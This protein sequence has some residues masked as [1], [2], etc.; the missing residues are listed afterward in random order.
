MRIA[1]GLMKHESNSFNPDLTLLKD[2]RYVTRE[3]I[4]D[5]NPAVKNSSLE[6]IIRVLRE[7]DVELIPLGFARASSEGGFV[8][9]DTYE[10]IKKDFIEGIKNAGRI[11]GICLDLHGSMTVEGYIDAEGDLLESIR[12]IIGF[13]IPI[14]CALDLHAMV[15]KQMITNLN[16]IVGYR[17]APHVDMVE[18]GEKA[19]K[20]L[21]EALSGGY[22]LHLAG[23][24]LPMLVS[25]EQ[26]ETQKEPMRTL[27]AELDK[28]DEI[29]GVLSTSYFLGF[30][31]ADVSYN[32][33]CA[34]VV[35]AELQLA[36]KEAIVL[37]NK[38]WKK[39][40]EFKFTTEAYPFKEG[41]K[42]AIESKEGPVFICDSGDNPG[43]GGNSNVTYPLEVMIESNVNRAIVSA[44]ADDSAYQFCVD[45]GEKET[46]ELNLGQRDADVESGP[47]KIEAKVKLLGN[48][49]GVPAAVV[50]IKGIDVVITPR[51]V[52]M[53]DPK[54]LLGL[55]LDPN[56]YDLV[57]L[58]S[59]YLDPK[60]E[61]YAAKTFLGLTPGYTNQNLSN[62]N[63]TQVSRPIYPLDEIVDLN[64]ESK[65][66]F[67]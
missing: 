50:E 25:G 26:S 54:F 30:P 35:A 39:H 36:Q 63:Y 31:W 64:A 66:I 20:I 37:A 6:G 38:F 12:S 45:A 48:S 65:V 16:G 14:V 18:T 28:V 27:L 59:G 49:I 13:D 22:S 56:N 7:Y 32:N 67:S 42:L 58:K 60:Y 57:V 21:Y 61:T 11:D 19:A 5:D 40:Q 23:V 62:L 10:I 47:L 1:V 24:P 33:G 53:T 8:S 29:D 17:T 9:K 3:E 51:R 52:M 44:I 41:L 55:G 34:L 4:L 46:F 43:A 2:F 15:T